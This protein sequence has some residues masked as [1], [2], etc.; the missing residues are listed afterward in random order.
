ML[1]GFFLYAWGNGPAI[2][3][4]SRDYLAAARSWVAVKELRGPTGALYV[5]WGPLYPLLLA[6]IGSSEQEMMRGLV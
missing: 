4:D 5:I 3:S 6:S 2:T 1:L